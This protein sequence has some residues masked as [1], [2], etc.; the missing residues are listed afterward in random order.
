MASFE[1][2]GPERLAGEIPLDEPLRR[3]ADNHR[4]GRCQPLETR[5]NIRCVTQ[6]ELFLPLPATY[7]PHH[8]QA[9]VDPDTHRQADT[10]T[11]SQAVI[12]RFHGL[13]KT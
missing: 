3:C 8:D 7:L 10:L 1:R 11:L 2:L 6:S 5:R 4:I 12:E 13:N 9:G